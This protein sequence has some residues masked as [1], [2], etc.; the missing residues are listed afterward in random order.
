[1]SNA[2]QQ[3]ASPP[4]RF[5]VGTIAGLSPR[6]LEWLSDN[7]LVQIIRAVDYPFAG[8]ERLEYFDRDTLQRVAHLVRRWCRNKLSRQHDAEE[9]TVATVPFDRVA[10]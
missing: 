10:G 4:E 9:A 2:L 1:M 3:P 8:K 7:E 6:Q 5:T